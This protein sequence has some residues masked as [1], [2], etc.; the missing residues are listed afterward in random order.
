MKYLQYIFLASL[1]AM[2]SCN[3]VIDLYP[4][5]NLNTGTYY[6]NFSEVQSALTGVYNGLQAPMTTE[7]TLT[8][9]RSDNTR[10]GVPAS[11]SSAN[12]D[13]SDLDMF[14]PATTH[15]GIYTYWL[16]TYN[17]IRNANIVL[18]RLG[19][20][21]DA[22]TG[23]NSL[24]TFTLPISEADRKQLAGEALFIRAHH[25][26]NLVRLYGGVFLVT[27][28]ISAAEA[29]T[30]SRS[31]V[32]D[33]YKL[34]EA[35]LT[36]AA[37]YMSAVKYA[38]IVA[39]NKGR[40]NSWSA[41]ALLGKV[42]LTQ[43]KK[44]EAINVLNDVRLNSGYG[45]QPTYASVFAITNEMNSEILFAVR[46]KAGG[47]G[48]GSSFGNDFGPLNSGSTVIN[49]S[50]R[51]LN[52]P[53]TEI[54][55]AFVTADARR[56]VNIGIY[57]TG[58]ALRIY[59]KKYLNPVVLTDDGEADW[60]VIRFADVLLMLAE[61]QGYTAESVGYINQIRARAQLPALTTSINSVATFEQ[62][63][64]NERR[65]ELAFENQRWFD[66]LRFNK[67][68]TT[69]NAE[70][71]LKAHFAKEYAMHYSQYLPPTPTLL[72]LQNYVT[73]NRLLLP[74]PQHE[75]DTNTQLTIEQNPGY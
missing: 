1:V 16:N 44:T 47:F 10:Q 65:L 66:L 46:Y 34:I 33:I 18:E 14:I 20:T 5:S 6:S 43:N 35:D 30:K 75:I 50:G 70:Q 37:S 25:Y 61:A 74:I 56:N 42:Y 64:S 7:W 21:Y 8:E 51:G 62:A 3:K 19:V 73:T 60:P 29:K 36:T 55:T 63:L 4:Q 52:T 67:T 11:T 48:I 22:A 24:E 49:G 68:L 28:S 58:T 27:N 38:A 53:T 9:L 57:G 45:L 15:E 69:I 71:V 12:R 39:A 32:A 41:K 59:V 2:G 13:L 26:F 40:A 72:Q 54:D 23:A 31:S 17:N